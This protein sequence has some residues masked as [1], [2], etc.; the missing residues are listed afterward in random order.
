MHYLPLKFIKFCI[1]G[2][3]GLFIDFS[4]TYVFKEKIKTN[5]FFANSLGFVL[6]STN[7]YFINKLWT[8]H[9]H[10]TNYG[11]QYSQFLLVSLIGLGLN[12]L[13]I[14]ILN[15]PFKI[16]L[17]LGKFN[18]NINGI[19]FYWAKFMASFLVAFWNFGANKYFTFH[20]S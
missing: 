8:F 15:R 7:N 10:S 18:M 16:N 11:V 9:D 4:V 20:N 1:V 19:S 12:T 5:K 17:S 2:F 14:Y 13:I 6:G 3:S